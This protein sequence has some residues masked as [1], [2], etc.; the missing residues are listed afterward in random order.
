MLG[1]WPRNTTLY[2]SV[3][4]RIHRSANI[5]PYVYDRRTRSANLYSRNGNAIYGYFHPRV[6]R[7]STLLIDQPRLG[8]NPRKTGGFKIKFDRWIRKIIYAIIVDRKKKKILSD[9][10][11]L[12]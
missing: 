12:S 6:L 8:F 7:D 10:L 2:I 9:N 4:C 1:S 11:Q 5:V 3:H